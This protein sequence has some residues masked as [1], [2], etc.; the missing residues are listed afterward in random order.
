MAALLK[1]PALIV[2][3]VRALLIF[4]ISF[5]V[6]ITQE[7]QDATLMLVGSALAVVSLVLTGVTMSKTTPIA[8]PTLPEGTVVEVLTP[9]GQPNRTAVVV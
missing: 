4:A 1:D 2:G 8:N 9:E 5:G 6:A 3:L 7:Q